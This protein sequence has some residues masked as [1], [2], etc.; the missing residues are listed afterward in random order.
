MT[1]HGHLKSL[2]GTI[3]VFKCKTKCS[4][5]CEDE[6]KSDSS[7]KQLM[8]LFVQAVCASGQRPMLPK[9]PLICCVSITK[10]EW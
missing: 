10:L 9:V 3:V 8:I 6:A 4:S 7:G 2:Q 1:F 5:C